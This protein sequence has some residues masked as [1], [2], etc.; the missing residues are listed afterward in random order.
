MTYSEPATEAHLAVQTRNKRQRSTS[1]GESAAQ[2][3]SHWVAR[4]ATNGIAANVATD[5]T[6]TSSS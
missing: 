5:R 2:S 1:L 3:R 6:T 4:E